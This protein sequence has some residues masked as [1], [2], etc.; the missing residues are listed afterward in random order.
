MSKRKKGRHYS[1]ARQP[2]P[3]PKGK[4]PKRAKRLPP[5]IGDRFTY[6]LKVLEVVGFPLWVYV[7]RQGSYSVALWLGVLLAIGITYILLGIGK[8]S[9]VFAAVLIVAGITIQPH[10]PA[11]RTPMQGWL[12][13]ADEPTPPN[14]CW[15]MPKDAMLILLGN[16]A[17]WGTFFPQTIV[18]IRNERV[19]TMNEVDGRIAL[20]GKF[21]S[22]DGKIVAELRDNRFYVNPNNYFRVDRPDSHSLIVF[23][24]QDM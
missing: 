2:N 22:S 21:F 13:P 16:S 1:N 18:K 10:L 19:L 9:A 15:S 23:D 3:N 6:F 17:A 7:I 24:Q 4:T 8:K 20:S 5:G 12:V 14:P 11:P